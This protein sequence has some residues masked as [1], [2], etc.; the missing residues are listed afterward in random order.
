V[1]SGNI[2][3]I[4]NH[5]LL[6]AVKVFNSAGQLLISASFYGRITTLM[7]PFPRG[8]YFITVSTPEQI[9]IVKTMLP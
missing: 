8:I 4:A 1:I 3:L 5:P 7:G 6:G 9:H 2:R